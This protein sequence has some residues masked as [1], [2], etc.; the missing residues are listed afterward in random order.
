MGL[1]TEDG[2]TPFNTPVRPDGSFV[3][4]A[5]LAGKY[6]PVLRAAGFFGPAIEVEGAPFHNGFVEL[7]TGDCG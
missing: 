2:V 1:A 3:F 7:S 5:V 6:H 4:P